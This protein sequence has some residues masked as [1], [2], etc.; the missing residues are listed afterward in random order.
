MCD[1][2]FYETGLVGVVGGD[3]SN[4]PQLIALR[5]AEANGRV[6]EDRE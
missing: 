4:L 6:V 5:R 1:H 2:V 3:N